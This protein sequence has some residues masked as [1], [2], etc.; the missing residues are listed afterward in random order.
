[1][2]KITIEQIA[3]AY[4]RTGNIWDVAKELGVSGQTISNRMKKAGLSTNKR[5][6]TDEERRAIKEYYENTPPEIFDLEAFCLSIN[7]S[8]VTVSKQAAAMGLTNRNRPMSIKAKMATT[9]VSKWSDKPHPRGF[10]GKRH[11]PE[12]IEKCTTASR[13]GWATMK[14]FGTGCMSPENLEKRSLQQ[15]LNMQKR[16]AENA[17]SRCAYGKRDDLPG[18]FFRSSWEANFARYLNLLKSMNV[19]DHWEFEPRTF[20][21]EGIKRGVMSYRPDFLVKYRS[22]PTGVYIEVKGWTTPKDKTKWKRMAE[23]YPDVRLQVVGEREYLAIKDKWSAQIP[24]W[25]HK[26]ERALI[27]A[28]AKK[29]DSLAERITLAWADG[30]EGVRI[31]LTKCEGVGP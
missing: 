2:K 20:R 22:D 16:T 28:T 26:K 7:R 11:S 5:W 14:A 3:A 19:V 9:G 18:M 1:M 29:D 12:T 23:F 15:S 30:G 27:R 13:T 31:V 10:G 25:E 8:L 6:V 17:Y 21:F 24:G 4:A